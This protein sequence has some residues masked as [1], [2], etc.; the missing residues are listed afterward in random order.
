[1]K[2]NPFEHYT[3]HRSTYFGVI[4]KLDAVKTSFQT[5]DR[6]TQRRMLLDSYIFAAI[7]VQTP[8]DIHE[9]AF[10]TYV[11]N[12]RKLE[13]KDMKKVNYWKNKTQYIRE[14]ETRFEAID[15]TIDLLMDGKIDKAHRKI[16]DT[17]KGVSTKKAAFTLA[18]LGYTEKM[19]IDTNVRQMA[20][21]SEEEEYTGVVIDRYESQCSKVRDRFPQL[22]E[23]LA[24]FMV[25][26]VLFD[27]IRE[28]VTTHQ[29]FLN[30]QLSLAE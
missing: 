6:K 25:Q 2:H 3:E 5:A 28:S 20:G 30:H 12:G 21:L 15:N 14:T 16:V 18:M 13:N 19:C 8:L 23:E 1:M 4:F 17:F 10:H 26:W 9:Q 27:S 22:S 24:P 29:E 7:S 11:N